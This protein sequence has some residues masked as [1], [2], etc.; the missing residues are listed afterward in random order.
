[1]S[2]G[3]GMLFAL[4]AIGSIMAS[5]VL[6]ATTTGPVSGTDERAPEAVT[7]LI[8]QVGVVP[9]TIQWALSPSDFVRQSP[10]GSDFTSGGSYANV[11]DVAVYEI[12]LDGAPVG[13]AQAGETTFAHDSA[14]GGLY[15][16]RAVDAGGNKSPAASVQVN[17]GP[18]ATAQITVP[19]GDFG[20]VAPDASATQTL[21]FENI[22]S[23]AAVLAASI[24]VSGAGF[25]VSAPSATVNPSE[26]ASVDIV[27]SS[28]LVGNLNGTYEG[29][30]T[31]R[32]NAVAEADQEFVIPVVAFINAGIAPP[33]LTVLPGNINFG[34]VQTGQTATRNLTATN[35]GGGVIT[36]VTFTQEGGVGFSASGGP[37]D[38]AAGESITA[39]VSYTPAGLGI[40]S[41]Q[42]RV[43]VGGPD[44]AD[45]IVGI[46]GRGVT[47]ITGPGTAVATVAKAQVRVANT[48]DLSNETARA[49]FVLAFRTKI[50]A[51]L[52]V[53]I[54]R[55]VVL[56]LANGST[57]VDFKIT[58]TGGAA[59]EPTAAAAIQTLVT[60]VQTA[61]D[62]TTTTDPL[63][64]FGGSQSVTNETEE[65]TLVPVD[66]NGDQVLGWF[67]F[68]TSGQVGIDDFFAF[69]SKFGSRTEDA[70]FDDQFDL[71]GRSSTDPDGL[72][73]ID[74][75]FTFASNFGKI[76]AN[77]DEILD[78]L[79]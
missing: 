16:V 28:A 14:I 23:D 48:I 10:T 72:V 29:T 9:V 57:I 67:T 25:S 21:L 38:L 78:A 79:N 70:N 26:S 22:S 75:F 8:H 50:A 45:I 77:K 42:V 32:S 35:T 19:D 39:T 61:V 51:I 12:T 71:T 18:P 47:A 54:G 74:D 13:T 6:A 73:G 55:V 7:D 63:A 11:N 34:Q 43:A 33:Q 52:N 36:G 2:R 40:S 76:V 24:S 62:D 1:M 59:G 68:G 15:E 20:V 3:K 65:V 58:N 5:P 17:L 46:T 64:D 30:V 53:A 41:G 44:L 49:D 31:V 56:N 60:T 37:G 66:A 27:F 69:A 4:V